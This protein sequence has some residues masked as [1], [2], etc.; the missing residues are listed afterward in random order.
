MV[1]VWSSP[2]ENAEWGADIDYDLSP[3]VKSIEHLSDKPVDTAL[4][5]VFKSKTG[6]KK[7]KSLHCPPIDTMETVDELWK[8]IILKFVPQKRIQFFPIKLIARGEICDD[9]MWVIPFDRVY[10]I[11][12]QKSDITQK[13]ELP[14]R[15]LIYGV[16]TFVHLPDCLGRLHLARDEEM[17]TH[18]LVSDELKEALSATGQDSPFYRAED[19]PTLY[20]I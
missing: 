17:P 1:W 3:G 10:S 15:T 4:R 16:R 20:N 7:F 11:D 9:F 13:R 18:M 12:K 2:R 6:L 19:V 8:S 5:P 14:D